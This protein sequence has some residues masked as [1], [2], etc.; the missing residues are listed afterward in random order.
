M[1]E[2]G[3]GGSLFALETSGGFI[4]VVPFSIEYTD[5]ALACA[6]AMHDE[7]LLHRDMD[8]DDAKMLRQLRSPEMNP[9]VY[10][11]IAVLNGE[12][13]GGLHAVALTIY[14]GANRI[15]KEIALFVKKEWRLSRA[16]ALLVKDFEQW[17]AE[18]GASHTMLSQ[19]TGLNIETTSR[20][21]GMLGYKVMGMTAWKKL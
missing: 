9:D 17:A 4:S 10:F 15:A 19:S 2:A 6:R 18:R 3:G 13:V 5:Q 1:V 11:K 20:F 14:F 21:Y 16:G 8:F 7:S 12:M